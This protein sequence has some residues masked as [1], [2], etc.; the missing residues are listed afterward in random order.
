MAG[1]KKNSR[2]KNTEEEEETA[3]EGEEVEEG[4]EEYEEEEE[5][6]PQLSKKEIKELFKNYQQSVDAVVEMEAGKERAEEAKSLAIQ[7]IYENV[8]KGP[9]RWKG[10]K[11]RVVARKKRDSDEYL[12][13]MRSDSDEVQDI[14]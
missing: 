12:Y 1:R 4:E 8:G 10:Q 9:F 14:A 5:E 13:F 3:V 11:L 7:A 2:K 6:R